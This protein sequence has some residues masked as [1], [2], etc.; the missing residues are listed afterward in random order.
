[1]DAIA[2]AKVIPNVEHR[3]TFLEAAGA[4]GEADAATI[5]S[6]HRGAAIRKG[7]RFETNSG[8]PRPQFPIA[9]PI[10]VGPGAPGYPESDPDLPDDDA[11]PDMS[12][13][14]AVDWQKTGQKTLENF[15]Q[16]ARDRHKADKSK[17]FERHYADL[18]RERPNAA[19]RAMQA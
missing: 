10:E 3:A 5:A 7:E 9:R 13:G 12:D 15:G 19:T 11:R 18:L 6:M 14:L 2:F 1:M 8:P 4:V 16:L 17:T